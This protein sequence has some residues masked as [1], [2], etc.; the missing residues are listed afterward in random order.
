M[1]RLAGGSLLRKTLSGDDD[2]QARSAAGRSDP[3]LFGPQSVAWRLHADSA[4]VVGGIRALLLQTLHPLAMAGVADH[5]NYKQDPFG[6]LARTG[7]FIGVTT[8]GSTAEANQAIE[9]VRAV[10]DRVRGTAPDG[11][12][13]E[14][15]DPRLLLWVHCVEIDSFIAT[16]DRYGSTRLSKADEDGYVDEMA[17]I[18]IRLGV[19]AD[20]VPRSRKAL[21]ATLNGFR[22][23][24]SFDRQAQES[25]RFLAVPPLPLAAR[26]P[27]AVVLAGAV[28]S[29]PRW[30][31]FTLRMP[32]LPGAGALAIRPATVA[33]TR[34]MGWLLD[35]ANSNHR[36]DR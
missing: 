22:P 7:R 11:R 25:V 21:T 4:I 24:L 17:E 26:G 13:Y 29:M 32:I 20:Q 33:M 9:V 1:V 5:S 18:A 15:N 12:P 19:D 28:A 30:A 27:Y 31:Q 35:A 23:E 14:A 16:V 10:H 8:Y 2:S 34:T 36:E 6:R 3:G